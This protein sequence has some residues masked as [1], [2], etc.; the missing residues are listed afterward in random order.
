MA[1]AGLLL[2]RAPGSR[3]LVLALVPGDTAGVRTGNLLDIVT[4]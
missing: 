3:T 2:L 1:P 4:V